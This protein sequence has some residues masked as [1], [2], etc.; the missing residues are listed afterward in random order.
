MK[1]MPCESRIWRRRR[2]GPS[3]LSRGNAAVPEAVLVGDHHELEPGIA[4][5]KKGGNHAGDEA[6]LLVRV[7]LF[8]RGLLDEHAVPVDEENAGHIESKVGRTRTRPPLGTPASVV[9]PVVVDAE[10]PE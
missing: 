8:V 4:E 1:R 2:C 7:D 9:A 10:A 5:A 6:E 3:K